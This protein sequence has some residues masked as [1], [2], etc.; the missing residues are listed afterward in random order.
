[1]QPFDL[2]WTKVRR[3]NFRRLCVSDDSASPR[4]DAAT[5]G[6]LSFH[7]YVS[8]VAIRTGFSVGRRGGSATAATA[9]F[10][11]VSAPSTGQLGDEID[12][13]FQFQFVASDCECKTKG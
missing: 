12:F 9:E 13:Q 7:A 2:I 6:G 10:I 8:T 4:G 5:K 3:V 1:M 11:S